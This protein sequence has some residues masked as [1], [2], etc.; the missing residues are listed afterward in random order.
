MQASCC[1]ALLGVNGAGKTTLMRLLTGV[2]SQ[3]YGE[4]FICECSN[5]RLGLL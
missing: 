1:M 2:I 4:A 5:G 3:T